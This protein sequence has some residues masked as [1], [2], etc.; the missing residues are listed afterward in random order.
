MKEERRAGRFELCVALR[1]LRVS[2]TRSFSFCGKKKKKKKMSIY[3][4]INRYLMYLYQLNGMNS[5]CV[6]SALR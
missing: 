4:Y 2:N 1:G 6:A 5:L 3:Q